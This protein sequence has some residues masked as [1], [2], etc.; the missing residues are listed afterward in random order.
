MPLLK[1]FLQRLQAAMIHGIL[2]CLASVRVGTIYLPS[3]VRAFVV[4]AAYLYHP[5]AANGAVRHPVFIAIHTL[6]T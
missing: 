6:V 4:A 2:C 3:T 5:A 1:R